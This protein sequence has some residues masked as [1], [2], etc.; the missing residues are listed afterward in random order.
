MADACLTAI[1]VE[2][3]AQAVLDLYGSE[4]IDGWLVAEEDAGVALDGVRVVARPL[5]MHDAEATAAIARTALDL[6]QELA[7]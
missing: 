3:T 6:A 4:L 2:T 7:R 5:L 1:G